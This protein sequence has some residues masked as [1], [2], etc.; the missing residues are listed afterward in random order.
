MSNVGLGC[1]L[2]FVCFGVSSFEIL[3]LVDFV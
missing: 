1:T 3:M 2:G